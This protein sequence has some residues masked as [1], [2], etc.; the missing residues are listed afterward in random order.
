VRITVTLGPVRDDGTEPEVN[1]ELAVSVPPQ[2]AT[3]I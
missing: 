3:L 1:G 2:L